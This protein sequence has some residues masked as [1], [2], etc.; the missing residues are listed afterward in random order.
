MV[1]RSIVLAEEAA[2]SMGEGLSAVNVPKELPQYL[3]P[4]AGETEAQA[5]RSARK[6]IVFDG[7]VDS[8]WIENMNTV[9]DDNKLLFLASGERIQ[10]TQVGSMARACVCVTCPSFFRGTL[11]L[12]FKLCWRVPR[13]LCMNWK[14][15]FDRFFFF[16]FFF[17]CVVVVDPHTP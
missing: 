1:L 14:S 4:V 11:V 12:R 13:G 2:A 7:P 15:I 6:W 10:L 5:M 16:F 8:L 17:F 3:P 9:L